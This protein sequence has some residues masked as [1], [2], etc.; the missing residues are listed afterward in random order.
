[1]VN[2]PDLVRNSCGVLTSFPADESEK[3]L[4]LLFLTD[5]K[6]DVAAISRERGD[7]H[8]G[9][10]EWLGDREEYKSWFNSA[11]PSYLAITGLPGIGKTTL[12][13][14]ILEKLAAHVKDLSNHML[15]YYFFDNK[16]EDRRTA[17]TLV[18]SLVWQAVSQHDELWKIMGNDLR[19]K[20]DGILTFDTLWMHL[21]SMIQSA[22][23]STVYILIDALDECDDASRSTVLWALS[24][25]AADAAKQAGLPIKI[26]VTAR[27]ETE[28]EEALGQDW[29]RL[30][31]DSA[32]INIDL[33]NFINSKVKD[34]AAAKHIPETMAGEIKDALTKHASGTFLWASFVVQELSRTPLHKIRRALKELPRGL[35]EVYCRI[36]RRIDKENIEDVKVILTWITTTARPLTTTELAL[37]FGTETKHW[38]DPTSPT[39]EEVSECSAIYLCCQAL[40]YKDSETDEIRL[41]HQSVK[42]FLTGPR[43]EVES[44]ISD[45]RVFPESANN[46][47]FRVCWMYL[48]W[49]EFKS[50]FDVSKRVD[51]KIE[52]I[53]GESIAD[54]TQAPQNGL[55][56]YAMENCLTHA[57]AA[58]T[59]DGFD[60]SILSTLPN[61]R[62]QWLLKAIQSDEGDLARRLLDNGGDANVRGPD[63]DGA[64]HYVAQTG[65]LAIARAIIQSGTNLDLKNDL[66]ITPVYEAAHARNSDVF[67]LFLAYGAKAELYTTERVCTGNLFPSFVIAFFRKKRTNN[68]QWFRT[69]LDVSRLR[70]IFTLRARVVFLTPTF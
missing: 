49:P 9:T 56:R 40:V 19:L 7:R 65:N 20:G 66:G 13:R 60:W 37:A 62:D 38:A 24:R 3:L 23:F 4:Q 51:S 30:R 5:P 11:D 31:I 15:L 39:S 44:D 57:D 63:G 22:S 2:G 45:S 16:I 33:M 64:L 35:D 17:L 47:V 32:L 26:V 29:L 58:Y 48:S 10:C 12:A 27:P 46:A 59:A 50:Y 34:M 43:L 68:Y 8:P 54:S 41:V 61:L 28:I 42:D 18:R 69:R 14:F 25:I 36:L 67:F 53:K 1:M 52:K 6:D 55:I 21:Q 70:V